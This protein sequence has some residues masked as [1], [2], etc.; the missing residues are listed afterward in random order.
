MTEKRSMSKGKIKDAGVYAS[1][2][3]MHGR[4]QEERKQYSILG[5]GGGGE[6]KKIILQ[7]HN[8]NKQQGLK[9]LSGRPS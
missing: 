1:R 5:G 6:E 4:K 9:C 8:E 3:E 7:K 2:G